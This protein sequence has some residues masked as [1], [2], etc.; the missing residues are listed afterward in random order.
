MALTETGEYL[1]RLQ[2]SH[3]IIKELRELLVEYRNLDADNQDQDY[4][5]DLS[6][7]TRDAIKKY[8][9]INGD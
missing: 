3:K 2:D 1:N 6:D 9:E 4:L 5:D 7:R 8:G